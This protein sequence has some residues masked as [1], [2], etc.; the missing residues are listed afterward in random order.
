MNTAQRRFHVV[1]NMTVALPVALVVEVGLRL[2][3]LQGVA[4]LASV[5]L[6]VDGPT[7]T[8]IVPS[9]RLGARD[10]ARYR[11]AQRVLHWWPFGRS[12]QCLRMALTAGHLLRH[13]R[14]RL[15]LGIV[16]GESATTAHAWLVIDG[17][18]F[19]VAAAACVPLA[20]P[21]S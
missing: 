12:G 21:S 2:V 8:H 20:R 11:A 16:R 9:W 17:M 6:D 1:A 10:D 5:E 13:R 18:T 3:G 14:P 19:D 7:Y 15:R 4:R